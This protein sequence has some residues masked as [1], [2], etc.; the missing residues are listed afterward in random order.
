MSNSRQHTRGLSKKD[1]EAFLESGSLPLPLKISNSPKR[2]CFQNPKVRQLSEKLEKISNIC[3]NKIDYWDN[4]FKRSKNSSYKLTSKTPNINPIKDSYK[5]SF[6]YIEQPISNLTKSNT[7]TDKLKRT[8]PELDNSFMRINKEN[9]LQ[10][11]FQVNNS[12]DMSSSNIENTSSNKGNFKMLQN[13]RPATELKLLFLKN[14]NKKALLKEQFID[15]PH[16]KFKPQDFEDS[17]IDPSKQRSSSKR[18]N[19]SNS[20]LDKTQGYE[21]YLKNIL[22]PSDLLVRTNFVEDMLN[23]ERTIEMTNLKRKKD[24]S[25][26]KERDRKLQAEFGSI[27][28]KADYLPEYTQTNR[29]LL[30][31][32]KES[33]FKTIN[34]A[35]LVTFESTDNIN[36]DFIN[37]IYSEK[38][39]SISKRIITDELKWFINRKQLEKVSNSRIGVVE[40]GKW[41]AERVIDLEDKNLKESNYSKYQSE[42]V[43]LLSYLTKEMIKQ[44]HVICQERG[45]LMNISWLCLVTVFDEG[46]S[47]M[48]N[49]VEKVREYS[50]SSQEEKMKERN[51]YIIKLEK[52]ISDLKKHSDDLMAQLKTK[53]K[54]LSSVSNKYT[55]EKKF[56]LMKEEKCRV[57][58][59]CFFTVQN[60]VHALEEK[61]KKINEN[62]STKASQYESE[63]VSFFNDPINYLEMQFE[64]YNSQIQ[65]LHSK[66]TDYQENFEKDIENTLQKLHGDPD[67]KKINYK[68]SQTETVG[69]QTYT[70]Q[71]KQIKNDIKTQTEDVY[72]KLF[73]GINKEK[74]ISLNQ[75]IEQ[76]YVSERDL[77]NFF[78]NHDNQNFQ[79]AK[80]DTK[81][82]M[83]SYQD[84]TYMIMH[85][86][87]KF[88]IKSYSEN[89]LRYDSSKIPKNHEN[90]K[91]KMEKYY[92]PTENFLIDHILNEKK[93][94]PKI[95]NMKR[96]L[97]PEVPINN[98]EESQ[99]EITQEMLY[100]TNVD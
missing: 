76:K 70:G 21:S 29:D 55:C 78:N 87:G 23:A 6:D 56:T 61:I 7:Y 71:V 2:L 40:L 1:K 74:K 34:M 41:F 50:K 36:E 75:E 59:K 83:N 82:D 42:L 31:I 3:S 92:H 17:V 89:D 99:K 19:S 66:N 98:E 67:I 80:N 4:K 47:F 15:I 14:S 16:S 54:Q 25:F 13:I 65:K 12:F 35:N 48:Q 52:E 20:N 77:S 43:V 63:K 51:D 72:E 85:A 79:T 69:L 28:F 94:K 60:F 81:T 90:D 8:L 38:I 68:S 46:F 11:S 96:N 84:P 73:E 64:T 5:N 9:S 26:Q 45:E 58:D 88:L 18:Q 95:I 10:E 57:S 86:V 44:N 37:E 100:F 91:K 49:V 22:K 33:N 24:I 39:K 93:N 30:T 97:Y 53:D 62:R 27:E 32:M